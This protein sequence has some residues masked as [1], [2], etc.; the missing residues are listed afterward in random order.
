[1][2]VEVGNDCCSKQLLIRH[3]LLEAMHL[4]LVASYSISI[5][6]YVTIVA[7]GIATSNNGITGTRSY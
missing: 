2:T 4:F 6:I 7:K 3:L 5:S 1:M